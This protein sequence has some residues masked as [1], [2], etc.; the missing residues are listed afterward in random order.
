MTSEQFN[1]LVVLIEAIVA[2]AKRPDDLHAFACRRE[3]ECIAEE[4]LVKEDG[5]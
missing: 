1:A 5:E 4:L 3:A 2:E